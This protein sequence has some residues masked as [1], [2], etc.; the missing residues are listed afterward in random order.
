[1]YKRNQ[2]NE[3][4][5]KAIRSSHSR[6]SDD[7]ILTRIKR[8][9]DFDRKSRPPPGANTPPVFAFHDGEAAGSGRDVTFSA[10]SVLALL[11]ALRLMS[12][13]LPQGRAVYTLRRFREPL[14]QEHRRMSEVDIAS[15]LDIK[16]TVVSS[17]NADGREKLIAKGN[18]V[19][20]IES[21]VFFCVHADLEAVGEVTRTVAGRDGPRPDNICRGRKELERRIALD[22]YG[23]SPTLVVELMN[24]FIQLNHL[25][26]KTAPAR[27]G[28][29]RGT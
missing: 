22:A 9:L 17:A 20:S 13:G 2:I 23:Q 24:S 16:G 19:E 25:L 12:C 18:V 8:L 28:R 6:L 5:V 11:V 21:M 4:L 26:S 27:R 29:R 14:E 7:V 15:L 1:M 10:Y 3:V